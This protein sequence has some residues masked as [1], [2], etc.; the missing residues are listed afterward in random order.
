[1]PQ[2]LL[3]GS[4]VR[5]A[6]DGLRFQLH[7]AAADAMEHPLRDLQRTNGGLAL[8]TAPEKCFVLSNLSVRPGCLSEP[9][10]P[11]INDFTRDRTTGLELPSCTTTRGLISRWTT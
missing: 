10:V 6:H 2:E 4:E 3:Q 9:R 8:K 11:G 1:M 7:S 5:N